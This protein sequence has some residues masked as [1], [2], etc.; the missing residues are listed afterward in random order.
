MSTLLN[1]HKELTAKMTNPNKPAPYNSCTVKRG[2]IACWQKSAQYGVGVQTGNP[3]AIVSSNQTQAVA[4]GQFTRMECPDGAC[5]LTSLA[6]GP[7]P[8]MASDPAGG[9]TYAGNLKKAGHNY[10]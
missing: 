8:S 4:L 6:A 1:R 5:P 9:M 2:E 7:Q 10:E 3:T